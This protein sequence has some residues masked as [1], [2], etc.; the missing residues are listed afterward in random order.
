M[1][2]DQSMH[3][4]VTHH[5]GAS[6][7]TDGASPAVRVK[8]ALGAAGTA[9]LRAVR[10]FR[11]SWSRHWRTSL[12]FRTVVTT[13]LIASVAVVGVGGYLAGQISSGLF[14][15]RLVQ[16]PAARG[17]VRERHAGTA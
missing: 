13:L 4:D 10:R 17:D 6:G 14:K 8:K 1:S 11:N 5:A 2:Q 12:Q 15:E 9:V 7:D 3:D 16:R